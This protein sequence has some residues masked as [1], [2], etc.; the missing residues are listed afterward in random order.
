VILGIMGLSLLSVV[1]AR[2][3]Y[4]VVVIRANPFQLSAQ[5]VTGKLKYVS[6]KGSL[7]R[8]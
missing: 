3:V 1:V 5:R 8:V 7:L 6:G 4:P 2:K